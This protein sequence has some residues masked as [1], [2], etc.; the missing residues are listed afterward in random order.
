MIV[1]NDLKVYTEQELKKILELHKKWLNDEDGGVQAD[2]SR[3]D[4]SFANLYEVNLKGANLSYTDLSYANLCYTD[5]SYTD[6]SYANLCYTNLSSANLSYANLSYTD[7]SSANLCYVIGEMKSLKS[8]Q[9]EKYMISYT[10]SI[11]NISCQSYDIEEW[12]DFDDKKIKKMEDGALE[13]WTKWKPII[14]KIIEMSPAEP[15]GYVK[16][17]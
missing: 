16:K 9:I 10:N 2:L 17:V 4:L 12:R 6:L 13:W 1:E 15:T 3:V 11:L 8:F 7:L 14:F 5:L